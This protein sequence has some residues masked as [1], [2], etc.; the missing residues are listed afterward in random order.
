MK[1]TIEVF[2]TSNSVMLVGDR[3]LA[4]G[5]GGPELLQ[6]GA[7]IY[8]CQRCPGLDIILVLMF[9]NPLQPVCPSSGK[10]LRRRS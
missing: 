2:Y 9:R 1:T 7:Q 3:G 6:R 8:V 5:R 4:D 10:L